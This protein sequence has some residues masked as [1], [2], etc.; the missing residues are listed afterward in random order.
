MKVTIQKTQAI[1]NLKS[2]G[3]IFATKK[4]KIIL[5][6]HE[7]ME[8]PENKTVFLGNTSW[9]HVGYLRKY[10]GIMQNF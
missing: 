1:R 5:I 8:I 10:H 3:V 2:K 4:D 7:V 9:G 6:E